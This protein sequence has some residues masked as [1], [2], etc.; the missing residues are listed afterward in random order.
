M[1][2]VI[3]MMLL[4]GLTACQD[5]DD[6]AETSMVTSTVEKHDVS[7]QAVKKDEPK[8]AIVQENTVQASQDV[9]ATL[10]ETKAAAADATENKQDVM[11]T[12][13][14][15]ADATKSMASSAMNTANPCAAKQ[16][17]MAGNPCHAK[18][19]ANPCSA[20]ANM[21]E[22]ASSSTAASA[23]PKAN[24]CAA[25][26]AAMKANPCAAKQAAMAGNPCHAKT[27][28]NPCSAKANMGEAASSSSAASAAP[29]ANPC[30]AKMAAMETNIKPFNAKKCKAC[31]SV[32]KNKVG[33]AW[34]DVTAAYGSAD[35]L[36]AVFKSGFHVA[37]RKV[38]AANSKW[39][40]K[41]G[42]MTAQYKKLIKDNP[43]GAAKALFDAVK[44]GKI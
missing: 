20:K 21:G 14:S 44:A 6:K 7:T 28:A 1:K 42:M 38:I 3:M 4:L 24:P 37:D 41:A 26:M 33:P 12:A 32:A 25:K 15:T 16:A 30:A 40:G 35:A 13:N 17:A 29:K 27:M 10:A 36:A 19:M 18:T 9:A 34:K 39:K 22:A 43:D 5:N 23:A 11:A 8:P 31:H 2:I